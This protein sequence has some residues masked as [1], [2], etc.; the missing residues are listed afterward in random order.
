MAD[1]PEKKG[2]FVAVGHSLQRLTSTDGEN[3]SKP[4]LGKSGQILRSVCYGNG[5]FVALGFSGGSNYFASSVDGVTWNIQSAGNQFSMFMREIVFQNGKFFGF[6]GEPP[7]IQTSEDGI[8]WSEKTIFKD[9]FRINPKDRWRVSLVFHHVKFGNDRF[10]AVGQIGWRGTSKDGMEWTSADD[11]KTPDAFID[12]A[13]GNGVFV[14]GGL[15]GL[16]MTSVDGIK[17]TDRVIGEEGEHINTMLWAGDR[18]VGIAAGATYISPDGYK[19]ERQPNKNAP[20]RAIYANGLFVGT[21]WKG[22][23]LTSP[24]AINWKQVM[25]CD[26]HI[27]CIAYGG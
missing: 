18:F 22:R 11:I 23:V 7:F 17:W 6:G 21:H 8:T 20:L 24:D 5:R 13:C 15:H 1:T 14:G 10:I 12:I 9:G 4:Q 19:W 3:W 27:E 25:K 16:R 26:E 2:M